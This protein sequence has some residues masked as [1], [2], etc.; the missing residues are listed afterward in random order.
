[1]N[2]FVVQE[3]FEGIATANRR[4]SHDYQI[5]TTLFSK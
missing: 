3:L 5:V 1:M 2:T 4:N